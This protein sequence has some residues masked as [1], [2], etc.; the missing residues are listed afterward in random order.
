ME[1]N[2]N[3]ARTARPDHLT[4]NVDV[5]FG[6]GKI[7]AQL[8]LAIHIKRCAALNTHSLFTQINNFIEIEQRPAIIC[9]M[10]VCGRVYAMTHAT[11]TFA[12][13]R[14]KFRDCVDGICAHR[15]HTGVE[16]S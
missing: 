13:S 6:L 3:S 2:A 8:E 16:S 5:I 10:S 15:L 12:E 9:D 4:I 14:A 11:A 1:T 7:K